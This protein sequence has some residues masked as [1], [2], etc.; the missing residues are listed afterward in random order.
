M[1]AT[2]KY[3]RYK[4]K[5]ENSYECTNCTAGTIETLKHIYLDCPQ[6]QMFYKSVENFIKD[7]IDRDY[8]G[9]KVYQ[10]TCCHQNIAISY[11][12][13][14]ANWYVG[15]KLQYGKRL[16]WDEFYKNLKML[17]IG[18]KTAVKTVLGEA[19]L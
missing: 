17:Q 7:K 12:Y 10:F 4:M 3:M 2:S 15:R 8:V 19:C 6:T 16:Y 1:I 14:T 5:I 9:D 18:E 11:I 13:L